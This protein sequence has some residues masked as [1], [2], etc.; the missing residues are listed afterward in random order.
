M[1]VTNALTGTAGS[2]ILVTGTAP[3]PRREF[4]VM[5]QQIAYSLTLSDLTAELYLR[6]RKTRLELGWWSS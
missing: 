1:R 6:G 4:A 3:R 5:S 2:A